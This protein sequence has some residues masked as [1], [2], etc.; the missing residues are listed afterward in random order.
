MR[1]NILLLCVAILVGAGVTFWLDDSHPINETISSQSESADAT[2]SSPVPDFSFTDLNGNKHQI[3]D[4]RGK[5]VLLN[6]WATWCAPCVIEFPKLITVAEE[7][8]DIVVVALSSD[9]SDDNIHRFLA[10][11]KKPPKNF[12]IV[13]DIKRKITSDIFNTYK[14]PETQIVNASGVMVKKIVGDTDWDSSE[15]KA[16]LS[17]LVKS[18]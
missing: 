7:H 1:L 6:F 18:D 14:L 12:I 8:T 2:Q 4:F 9:V 3:K 10:K 11:N 13:R 5:G 15:M 17:S 16:F